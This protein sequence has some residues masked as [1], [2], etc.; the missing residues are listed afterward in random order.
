MKFRT[1]FLVLAL[2]SIAA[3]CGGTSVGNPQVT[4]ES[5]SY[6]NT[7][8]LLERLERLLGISHAFAAPVSQF[9]FCVT[10]LKL[11]D[12]G[13]LPV[14]KDG[15]SSIEAILG[16]IDVSNSATSTRWGTVSIPVDF[17]LKQMDVELHRDPERCSGASYSL[18]YNGVELTKDLEF[19][20]EFNPVVTVN[21][22]D[23]LKLGLTPIAAA[24]EQ[25]SAAGKL[26][27]EQI[28][29]YLT[30]T[31]QGTGSE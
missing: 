30:S 28:G 1:L 26:N 20:F 5:T 12:S 21:D 3:G 9:K 8:S 4:L 23:V 24:L 11:T 31:T 19:R 6:G 13:G 18:S 25:A 16:L 15:A 14:S 2:A 27:N 7:A 29:E 10:K 17:S 22:G